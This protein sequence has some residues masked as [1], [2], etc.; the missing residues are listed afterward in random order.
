[1]KLYYGWSFLFVFLFAFFGLVDGIYLED[2]VIVQY[3][4]DGIG[5]LSDQELSSIVSVVDL[6]GESVEDAVARLSQD[7][8]VLYVQPNYI[9]HT[10]SFGYPNDTF[11]PSQR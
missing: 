2:Q 6:D 11:F 4:I 8:D 3:K 9:Y 5:L 7:P 1:M 10:Q